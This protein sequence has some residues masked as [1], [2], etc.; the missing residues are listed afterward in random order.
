[1]DCRNWGYEVCE[2]LTS[3]VSGVMRWGSEVGRRYRLA[4]SYSSRRAERRRLPPSLAST[5]PPGKTCAFRNCEPSRAFRSTNRISYESPF[6]GR[7][8]ITLKN[9][10]RRMKNCYHAASFGI[11]GVRFGFVFGVDMVVN[12]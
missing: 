12:L 3:T 10:W 6:A 7:A 2:V 1:M 8:R 5:C 9:E 11:D 4:S